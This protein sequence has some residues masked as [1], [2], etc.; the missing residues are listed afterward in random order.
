[1]NAKSNAASSECEQSKR[2]SERNKE[3]TT[4]IFSG[5]FC[6]GFCSSLLK[7]INLN[8]GGSLCSGSDMCLSV[9]PLPFHFPVN[10]YASL[11]SLVLSLGSFW[12]FFA[13]LGARNYLCTSLVCLRSAFLF[14]LLSGP[15][16]I[17]AR[18]DA[19]AGRMRRKQQQSFAK[20]LSFLSSQK[21]G[22]R[23]VEC[24]RSDCINAFQLIK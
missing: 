13:R 16:E 20:R 12:V 24:K 15:G 9:S 11:S 2:K 5:F 10:A 18:S 3:K 17:V 22:S 1:M 21:T 8:G 6:F 4:Q 23:G 19:S 7:R 14:S